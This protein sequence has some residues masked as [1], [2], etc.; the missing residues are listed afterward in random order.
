MKK[1][2]TIVLCGSAGQG[3]KT[4]EETTVA[5]M[6]L[7]GYHV[8]ATKEYM[9]RIRGGINSTEI[10]VGSKRVTSHVNDID[11]LI[12]LVKDAIDHL[13]ERIT[14]NTII[15][16]EESNITENSVINKE[17]IAHVNFS[18]LATKIGSKIFSNI[19][20]VGVLAAI[21]GGDNE[22]AK[23]FI[24]KKFS[25]KGEKLIDQNI[26]AFNDGYNIGKDIVTNKGFNFVIKKN[27]FIANEILF[28][29]NQAVA[30][31]AIAGGCNFI[32]SY[33]MSPA[34][35][36]LLFLAQNAENFGI[37]V[38]QAEDEIAAMVK[39]VAAW[40]AGAR[41]LVSTSG[42]GYA[43]M[44]EGLSLAAMV[45]SPVVIHIAQRP[46]PATGLPT[47]TAQEDLFHAL[48]SGHGEFHRIILAP[49]TI[50][51]ALNLTAKAFTLADKYQ[52]PVFILTDQY[53]VDS[54]YNIPNVDVSA[55]DYVNNFIET[56]ENYKRYKLTED[57]L[58]PRGI[59][60]YGKGLVRAD[61]DEHDEAGFITE[62]V[63]YLR[64]KMVD[65]RLDK[66]L[67]L[68]KKDIIPPSY[69]GSEDFKIL[70]IAWGSTYHTI[71]EAMELIERKDIGFL[72]FTQVFPL[73]ASISNYFDK[74]E[75]IIFL[76]N[77]ATGQFADVI[78]LEIGY[79]GNSSKI[80]KFLKYNG[81]PYSVKEVKEY[82][83]DLK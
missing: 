53:F 19:I 55:F 31:G 17:N 7:T 66:R 18:E 45:E 65:K 51:D 22:I 50:Q 27:K 49:G 75:K 74:A 60:G 80:S 52:V 40:Y 62:D 37:V 6:K 2:F 82:L 5:I 1:D 23:E 20:A 21:L 71:R 36:V 42:G 26:Q 81:L 25:K 47:R 14:E 69:I 59:P 15:I 32:S 12:P 68:L 34:T 63:H 33:P 48:K 67:K 56:D 11:I 57:G 78:K 30:I 24:S 39:T 73:D 29:G 35:G 41:A 54:Y 70:V 79:N 9:S 8:Y 38:D 64:P 72:H 16:S 28:N 83:E 58:S 10:R 44:T 46:G 3:I 76:E 4:V 13:K 77:N 43:L 61:S